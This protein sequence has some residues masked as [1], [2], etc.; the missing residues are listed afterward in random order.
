M[1]STKIIPA[2]EL[3]Q[4][5]AGYATED[6]TYATSCP[7]L[8]F[9]RAATVSE[10]IHTVYRPS[11]C[12]VAQGVKRVTLGAESYQY[13]PGSFLAASVHLPI[14][15]QVIEASPSAP[16]LSLQLQFDMEQILDVMQTVKSGAPDT[17]ESQRGL[18]VSLMSETLHEAVLRLV[19]LL[20]TPDDIPALAPYMIREIL[21]RMLQT[22]KAYPLVSSPCSA[23]MRNV[24]PTSLND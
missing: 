6:G 11:L 12:I 15:G 2:L 16:Y 18:C 22:S 5:I 7:D 21:Y 20:D 19:R 23:A 13:D 8:S 9:I 14:T 4:R 24:S 10:P 3:A 17:S 1:A